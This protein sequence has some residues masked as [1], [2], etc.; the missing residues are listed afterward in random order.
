[1]H[2]LVAPL[3]GICRRGE[4][5]QPSCDFLIFYVAFVL[6]VRSL[7]H[8][9]PKTSVFEAEEDMAKVF[10]EIDAI[11]QLVG[12]VLDRIKLSSDLTFYNLYIVR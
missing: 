7:S 2:L 12:A 3:L 10:Y 5:F 11:E 6:L 9:M 8:L 4:L 1:M